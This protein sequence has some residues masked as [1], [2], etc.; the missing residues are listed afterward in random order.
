MQTVCLAG[1]SATVRVSVIIPEL[2]KT[3][4]SKDKATVAKEQNE[5]P[6]KNTVITSVEKRDGNQAVVQTSIA[7]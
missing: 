2:P 7:R 1:E 4:E 3:V 5:Q 6:S